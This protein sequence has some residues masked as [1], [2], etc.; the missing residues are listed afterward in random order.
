MN[1]PNDLPIDALAPSLSRSEALAMLRE[2]GLRSQQWTGGPV[3][4]SRFR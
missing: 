3:K 4:S 2:Q 1:A